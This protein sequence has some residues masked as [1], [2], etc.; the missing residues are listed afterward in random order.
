M[1]LL[2]GL[3]GLTAEILGVSLVI[4]W[5]YLIVVNVLE[6]VG[7]YVHEVLGT[8]ICVTCGRCVIPND[9]PGHLQQKHGLSLSASNLSSSLALVLIQN[10]VYV[11]RG[12]VDGPV[13]SNDGPPVKLLEKHDGFMCVVKCCMYA[14]TS[15]GTMAKHLRECHK[16]LG[17]PSTMF[18]KATIQTL[19]TGP[20]KVFFTVDPSSCGST[21]LFESLLVALREI[22]EP[23]EEQVDMGG[24]EEMVLERITEWRKTL[25]EHGRKKSL[26]RTIVALAGPISAKEEGS[27]ALKKLPQLC[28]EYMT[29]SQSLASLGLLPMKAALIPDK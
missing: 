6:K 2:C 27:E 23:A 29:S 1:I 20:R 9:I 21:S 16:G 26:R 19:F 11:H 14:C 15:H 17:P 22:P 3:R 12:P 10:R 18:Q 25:G 7:V 24:Q 8:L 5:S 13:P 28:K 4:G